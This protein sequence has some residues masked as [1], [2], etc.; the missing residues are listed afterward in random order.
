MS[1]YQSIYDIIV[2][3]IYGAPDVLTADMSLVATLMSSLGSVFCFA[4]PFIV[5]FWVARSLMVWR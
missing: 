1:I 5:V 4:L 2:T 3:H